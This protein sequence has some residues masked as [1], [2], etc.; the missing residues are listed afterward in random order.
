VIDLHTHTTASDGRCSPEEL[1][2]RAAAN[3]VTVLGVTDHDTMAGC[4]AASAA[5]ERVGVEFVAGIEITAVA[6]ERDVHVLAYFH[7]PRSAALGAFLERQRR[8]RIE[9]LREV[10]ARLRSFDIQLDAEVVLAPGLNDEARAMGRPMIARAMVAA[11]HASSVNDAFD[12]WLGRGRPAFVPRH[13]ATPSDVIRL[14]QDAGGI[15]SLAH[16]VLLRDDAWIPPLIDAGLDAIEA[17]HS[18][19][20]DADTARYLALAH[21]HDL[22]VTGGSDYHADAEHGGGGPGRVSLPRAEYDR[23]R[24]RQ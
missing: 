10:M 17:Y 3:G 16:P 11:G 5:C 12:R 8:Y 13:G 9:R 15:A 24:T 21:A 14:V 18:D 4:A 22:L 2:A 19:H 1:V 6:S 23:L 20:T 7:D